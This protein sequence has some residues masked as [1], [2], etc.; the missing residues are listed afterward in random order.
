M[1]DELTTPGGYD[2]AAL[3]RQTRQL[4]QDAAREI[5]ARGKRVM[6]DTIDI[7]HYLLSVK[8]ALPH[9]H[10]TQWIEAEFGWKERQARNFMNIAREFK[11]AN[12]ADLDIATS[13]LGMLAAPSTPEEARVEALEA[14]KTD[15][16]DTKEAKRIIEKHKQG[17]TPAPAQPATTP[18]GAVITGRKKVVLTPRP[19]TADAAD[20][21]DVD[22]V[23]P[24]ADTADVETTS[25]TDT[26][27]V[28]TADETDDATIYP[29]PQPPRTTTTPREPYTVDT[30]PTDTSAAREPAPHATNPV[31]VEMLHAEVKN[32]R[33]QLDQTTRERDAFKMETTAAQRQ[34]SAYAIDI[35][36]LEGERDREHAEVERLTAA[37]AQADTARHTA[38]QATRELVRQHRQESEQRINDLLRV[39]GSVDGILQWHAA[40][41]DRARG[42]TGRDKR[43]ADRLLPII[44]KI[45]AL[46]EGSEG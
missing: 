17:N 45:R 8:E 34:N 24:V 27:D 22:H 42:Y 3:D 7:G 18:D 25:E 1:T 21:P 12:F 28:E 4:A 41:I 19:D 26:A 11:T 9:G 37:L 36:R 14:A 6:Q 2:Y 5:R 39:V 40:D 10:F 20:L 32:L 44:D 15:R 29:L 43:T 33:R 31:E 30:L 16:V 46:I 23:E 35:A 38:E 13:A